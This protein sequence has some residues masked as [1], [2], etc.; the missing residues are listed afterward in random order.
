MA[1]RT[2]RVKVEVYLAPEIAE[3]LGKLVKEGGFMGVEKH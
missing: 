2:D 1:K 3:Q